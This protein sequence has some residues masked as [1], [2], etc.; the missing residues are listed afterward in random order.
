[1]AGGLAMRWAI[2]AGGRDAA[3]DPHTARLV[4]RKP[5]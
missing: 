4:S 1:L 2:T 3:D 5:A